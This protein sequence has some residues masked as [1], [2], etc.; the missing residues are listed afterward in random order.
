MM[1]GNKSDLNKLREVKKQDAIEYA[2]KMQMAFME[3]SALIS[4]NVDE[5]FDTLISCIILSYNYYHRD[6]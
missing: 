4:T 6:S 3:T 5:A 2:E 1:V